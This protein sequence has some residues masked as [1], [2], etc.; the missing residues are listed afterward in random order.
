MYISPSKLIPENAD[1]PA[2]LFTILEVN[3]GDDQNTTNDIFEITLDR[4]SEPRTPPTEFTF[5]NDLSGIRAL[6]PENPDEPSSWTF[7]RTDAP[8]GGYAV[9]NYCDN[10]TPLGEKDVLMTPQLDVRGVRGLRFSFEFAYGGTENEFGKDGL[11]VYVLGN[12]DYHTIKQIKI[13]SRFGNRLQ[14]T[15]VIQQSLP[16]R[17]DSSW[18]SFS[19]E[20]PADFYYSE[21]YIQI[22]FV[23]Y[24]G[25]GNTLFLDNIRLSRT[26]SSVDLALVNFSPPAVT[27]GPEILFPFEVRNDGS[28]PLSEFEAILLGR[29]A[30][31][32]HEMSSFTIPPLASGESLSTV[33]PGV[34]PKPGDYLWTLQ[35]NT[36]RTEESTVVDNNWLTHISSISNAREALPYAQNFDVPP[37]SWTI[38]NPQ[39]S[40][41]WVY[42]NR[43]GDGM[44]KA[45]GFRSRTLAGK[46]GTI[47]SPLL[48]AE[49]P[50]LNL[51]FEYS[52]LKRFG[53]L[54]RFQVRLHPRVRCQP[55]LSAPFQRQRG[56]Q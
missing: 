1:S 13:F 54:D 3:G 8:R 6:R 30:D 43:S 14:T 56:A 32:Y 45:S 40:S 35:V 31:S 11:E 22:H 10:D 33:F 12:S 39:N 42:E 28:E 49:E 23:G 4:Q 24:F 27:C 16:V 19:M 37:A 7:E 47:Y 2:L 50:Q 46:T 25:Q 26:Q 53:L 55:G 29:G 52:Y 34:S 5:D 21:S 15:P 18:D 48:T 20:I 38:Q 17:N 44:M 51:Y 9:I 36:G 41:I